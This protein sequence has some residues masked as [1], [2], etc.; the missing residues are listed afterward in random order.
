[1]YAKKHVGRPEREI[2]V[3][4]L[5]RIF[6]F[7]SPLY[8]AF[9]TAADPVDRAV[10][11]LSPL[12]CQ[13]WHGYYGV[14]SAHHGEVRGCRR[15]CEHTPL[16]CAAGGRRHLATLSHIPL[17]RSSRDAR[18]LRARQVLLPC[19]PGGSLPPPRTAR[20]PCY[21]NWMGRTG[22]TQLL[23]ETRPPVVNASPF[24]QQRPLHL[25]PNRDRLHA[26]RQVM[27]RLGA[28]MNEQLEARCFWSAADQKQH[29]SRKEL[30]R[31]PFVPTAFART[32]STHARRQSSSGGFADSPRVPVAS[33]DGRI[34]ETMGIHRHQQ[35]HQ[36][37]RALYS[38]SAANIW[39]DK[40]SNKTNME[41]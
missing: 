9:P 31:S 34:S 13:V 15:A 36:H 24:C 28:V 10:G 12:P 14:S 23:V 6:F 21:T 1:M 19:R 41:D 33:H 30:T 11:P 37:S 18:W 4:V 29:M 22:E 27:L 3:P 35:Q 38:I 20:H 26:L 16:R 5:Q 25:L 2:L 39:A 7:K 17:R 32:K 40:L 8:R